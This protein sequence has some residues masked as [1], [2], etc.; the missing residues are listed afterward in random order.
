MSN[1]AQKVMIQNLGALNT[2]A[3]MNVC[4]NEPLRHLSDL[5]NSIWAITDRKHFFVKL[6]PQ[7]ASLKLYLI[8]HD[9]L[10]V[11]LYIV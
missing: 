9:G 11:Y 6:K 2:N 10:Y 4:E 7:S 3:C 8:V 5:I 1:S